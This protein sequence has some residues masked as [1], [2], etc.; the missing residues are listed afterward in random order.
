MRK[1]SLPPIGEVHLKN[2]YRLGMSINTTARVTTMIF[3]ERDNP[4]CP[5]WCKNDN[6]LGGLLIALEQMGDSVTRISGTFVDEDEAM[7]AE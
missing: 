3:A 7:T 4:D 6:L 2:L 1:K 5:P